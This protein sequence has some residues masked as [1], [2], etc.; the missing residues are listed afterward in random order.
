MGVYALMVMDDD[1]A[2]AWLMRLRIRHLEVFRMLVRTGSQ[3]ET[4]ALMHITQPALS[5]WLRELETQA[6]CALMERERPLRLTADGEVLLRYAER[7]FSRPAYI[8]ALTPSEKV[9]RR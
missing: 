2:A 3:S 6:G 5:K 7:L 8:E 4:A 9:M 1:K